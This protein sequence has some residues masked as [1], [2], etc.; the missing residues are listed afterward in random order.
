[1]ET[2]AHHILIGLFTILGIGAALMFVLWLGTSGT[3]RQYAQ[4][5]IVFRE[6]VTGLSRG[7]T[8]EF[9]GIRI[10]DVASLRLDPSDPSRV[11]ARVRVERDAPVR[12]DT[13]ARLVPAGITG[14]SFIRLSSGSDPNSTLLLADDGSIPVIIAQPSPMSRLM[15]DGEDVMTNVN[16]V[17]IRVT[18]LFSQDN[19]AR[20]DAT[21]H[22]LQEFTS[23]LAERRDD[24][25]AAID[26]T[27]QLL[28]TTD[29]LVDVELRG[30]LNDARSSMAAME[31]TVSGIEAMVS[32]NRGNL[33]AGLR[34]LADVGPA[35]SELRG[36]MASLRAITRE[37]EENPRDYLIG[38]QPTREFKP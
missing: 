3:D 24:L 28:Q 10:G 17:L 2:R 29:R 37:L 14:L 9:N 11:L 12:S 22:N 38:R 30:A 16:Q 7:S 31:R 36:T 20:L 13:Q 35:M 19:V 33:D 32:D 34:G 8:V 21:L 15:A 1:M 26:A 25:S 6:A 23:V 4:Y 27:S 5:D 18:E